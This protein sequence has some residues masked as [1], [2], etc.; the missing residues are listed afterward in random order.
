MYSSTISDYDLSRIRPRRLGRTDVLQRSSAQQCWKGLRRC[1]DWLSSVTTGVVGIVG[2]L[3][4]VTIS[5]GTRRDERE[6]RR[7]ARRQTGDDER[8]ALY[9]QLIAQG[10]RMQRASKEWTISQTTANKK[11]FTDEVDA[12]SLPAA[13]ARATEPPSVF[14]AALD[15]D[16]TY[17]Q[18]NEVGH[19][20][21]RRH[22]PNF[23]L[24][25]FWKQKWIGTSPTIRRW[26]I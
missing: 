15:I 22:D 19:P 20:I 9:T 3:A 18:H 23:K 25:P 4:T 1:R 2:I 11:H 7:E 12:F 14:E 13:Q 21:F 6:R 26:P 16:N 8:K 17:R 24:E 5:R 10:R